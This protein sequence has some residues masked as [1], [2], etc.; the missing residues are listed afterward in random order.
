MKIGNIYYLIP[1]LE[2]PPLNFSSNLIRNPKALVKEIW[3]RIKLKPLPIIG[4]VKIH[5]QHCSML[6][7]AGYQAYPV[8]MGGRKLYDFNYPGKVIPLEDLDTRLQSNDIVVGTE[9]CPYEA[10]SF[11]GGIKVVFVQNWVNLNPDRRFKPED[12]AKT[13]HAMG[14]DYI[15]SCSRFIQQYIKKKMGT[16]AYLVQNGINLSKFKPS[17]KN[18][19]AGRVLYMPRKNRQDVAKIRCL[20]PP[21]L[22]EFVPADG[23]SESELIAEFQKSDI[24]LATGYPEG[25]GLPP[26]EAMACGC[27]VV[28]FTG[29]GADEY[30]IDGETALVA[31]DGDCQAVAKK[32][33]VL[34][35]D[36]PLKEKIR[37]GGLNIS[38][39]YSLEIMSEKLRNFYDNVENDIN[40]ANH[41]VEINV[42]KG[43][44]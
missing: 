5:Y 20:L 25:F 3:K 35:K 9:F 4:G 29:K 30:M 15:L 44:A 41:A 6:N 16:D 31:E 12:D 1:D 24:F 11:Q 27:A 8:L 42:E 34:A 26:L 33:Q 10:L 22:F 28:G 39:G 2:S 18:R 19:I 7:D 36:D 38:S 40:S 14:Y 23:L 37:T 43:V 32:L 17:E 13:Y 21:N